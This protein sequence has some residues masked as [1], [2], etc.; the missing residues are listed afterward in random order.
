M[1]DAADEADD[2]P[3]YLSWRQFHALCLDLP[4]PAGAAIDT[5]LRIYRR[6]HEVAALRDFGIALLLVAAVG[7]ALL[8][9]TRVFLSMATVLDG[10]VFGLTCTL[11]VVVG[12]RALQ[13]LRQAMEAR[14]LVHGIGLDSLPWQKVESLFADTRV[15]AVRE[16]LQSVR[17]QGRTPRRAEVA[18]ALE[19][20]RGRPAL[21]DAG[22][23]AFG[24]HLRDR[25][26]AL[27]RQIATAC[28]CLVAL[29]L[30][31]TGWVEG[32]LFLP[33]LI[34]FGGWA[35]AGVLA[36]A[37]QLALDPWQLRLGGPAATRIR[38]ALAADL[39][40]ELALVLVLIVTSA[41]LL[42]NA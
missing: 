5:R 28:A 13:R 11:A 34:L 2:H 16:Y 27:P 37:L 41:R 1:V 19:R 25:D 29:L 20:A 24:R 42:G 10:L 4:A 17:E 35:L 38:A 3:G 26:G 15:A 8:D 39:L 36:C 18:V 23:G 22:S 31:A 6:A 7:R 14:A 40:P 9:G 12:T 32:R 33:A 21:D 30:A